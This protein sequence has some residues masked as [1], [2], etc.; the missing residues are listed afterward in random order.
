MSFSEPPKP[1]IL[2]DPMREFRENFLQQLRESKEAEIA[3]MRS[4]IHKRPLEIKKREFSESFLQPFE[5]T[6]TDQPESP[7]QTFTPHFI[8]LR[9]DIPIQYRVRPKWVGCAYVARIIRSW[10]PVLEEEGTFGMQL[11]GRVDGKHANLV[12][13]VDRLAEGSY[14][15]RALRKHVKMHFFERLVN[16][17]GIGHSLVS[18]GDVKRDFRGMGDYYAAKRKAFHDSWIPDT[19]LR[20]TQC[21]HLVDALD[22]EYRREMSAKLNREREIHREKL[23]KERRQYLAEEAAEEAEEA[24]KN[25][26][27]KENG[28]GVR[29]FW[30]IQGL[31]IP[32]NTDDT[33]KFQTRQTPK[34]AMFRDSKILFGAMA[35][36]PQDNNLLNAKA[37][38]PKDGPNTFDQKLPKDNSAL[39]GNAPALDSEQLQLTS[40]EVFESFMTQ[41]LD[42]LYISRT[43]LAF[44]A[45]G[46]LSRARAAFSK[47]ENPSMQLSDLTA[48][49]R[50]FIIPLPTMDKKYRD[51]VPTKLQDF[52]MVSYSDDEEAPPKKK[53][54]TMKLKPTRDGM[55]PNE[56]TYLKRWWLGGDEA[57]QVSR[58]E[59][60]ADQARKRR[61][62]GLR[63]RETL[64]QLILALE[65]L[66]IEASPKYNSASGNKEAAKKRAKKP[67]D[68]K[69]TVDLIVD[70][71][72]IWQSVELEDVTAVESRLFGTKQT[73][74]D[75]LATFCKEVI[76]PFFLSRLPGLAG[77]VNKKLGGPATSSSAPKRQTEELESS[78]KRRKPAPAAPSPAGK[79][80]RPLQAAESLESIGVKKPVRRGNPA[81]EV[82]RLQRREMQMLAFAKN[83]D[84]KVRQKAEAGEALK[85]AIAMAKRPERR[86]V[87]REWEEERVG[88]AKGVAAAKAPSK[89]AVQVAVT[90]AKK[91]RVKRRMEEVVGGEETVVDTPTKKV[92][93]KE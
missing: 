78:A 56:E 44:F 85:S 8:V 43:S 21:V 1:L 72:C 47:K 30:L 59:E 90:P 17:Q 23:E 55:F 26:R 68:L 63:V 41:Y 18:N 38:A 80:P 74:L 40:Q 83:T 33:V 71:L 70:K 34:V 32:G 73:S 79:K 66:A 65:I 91:G 22:Y 75:K 25:E 5:Y 13:V 76:I 20:E 58:S 12:H 37:P 92:K 39:D 24:A 60:T 64:M 69:T 50:D 31:A 6:A 7:P 15:I 42:T 2:E 93:T 89:E 84:A 46:P 77:G 87:G 48:F 54:K 27:Y 86:E 28:G 62:A 45:K 10:I 36:V 51:K 52:P 53:V 19:E 49:L 81:A 67:Q 61:A 57:G 88:R 16:R 82:G 35:N 29:P 9:E 3:K 4:R 14:Q 11:I